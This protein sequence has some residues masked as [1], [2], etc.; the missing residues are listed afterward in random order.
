[1]LRLRSLLIAS[2]CAACGSDRTSRGSDSGFDGSTDPVLDARLAVPDAS[3]PDAQLDASRSCADDGRPTGAGCKYLV[4]DGTAIIERLEAS[5]A[6]TNACPHDPVTVVFRFEPDDPESVRC[7][8]SRQLGE[9][10]AWT[11]TIGDGK[12]PPRACIDGAAIRVGTPLRVRRLD[13]LEGTCTPVVFRFAD[14]LVTAC[15]AQCFL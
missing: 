3:A 8:A 4:T 1:M 12:A 9:A 5:D 6:T 11:F 14:E 7:A 10:R 2:V 15:D 13:I